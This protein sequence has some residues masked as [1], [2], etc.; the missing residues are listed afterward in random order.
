MAKFLVTTPVADFSG[1]LGGVMFANGRAV[2]DEDTHPNELAYCRAK[3]T[4]EEYVA[5]EPADEEIEDPMPRKS[6]SK[7][8]WLAY[9]VEHGVDQAEAEA[10]TRDQLV[11]LFAS[12]ENDQ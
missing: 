10:L 4:V 9:A 5:D 3:Y 6:A 11:E 12:K 7:A 2:V 8:D 1:A